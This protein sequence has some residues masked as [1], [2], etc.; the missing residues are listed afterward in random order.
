MQLS[1]AAEKL[2]VAVVNNDA[3]LVVYSFGNHSSASE[4]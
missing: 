3:N 2:V 1:R 4:I